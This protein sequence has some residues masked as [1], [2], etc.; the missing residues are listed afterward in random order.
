MSNPQKA[1]EFLQKA[2]RD[3]RVTLLSI[4]AEGGAP[5]GVTFSAGNVD[6]M[7]SWIAEREGKSNL[8]FQ[9]NPLKDDVKDKKAKRAE[10]K[11]VVQLHVDI[12]DLDGLERLSSFE[13]PPTAVVFSGN[14]YHGYWH[15]DKPLT[16]FELVERINKRLAE[17]LGGDIGTQNVDRILRIPFTTN[18]PD[19]KKRAKGRV[20]VGA[21]LVDEQTNFSRIYGIA[22]FEGLLDE[23]E[24]DPANTGTSSEA[25]QVTKSV[26]YDEDGVPIDLTAETKQ[27]ILT[28]GKIGKGGYHSRS[29]A[30]FRVVCDMARARF[31]E[32]VIVKIITNPKFGISASVRDKAKPEVYARRQAKTAK[33]A[34]SRSWD[35]T[36]NGKNIRSTLRN[37]HLAIVALGV[38]CTFDR[39]K[40]R[41]LVNGHAVQEYVG[42]LTD[43]LEAHLRHEILNNF[44]FDPGKDNVRDATQQLALANPFNSI[45]DYFDGL[46]WDRV[47]RLERLLK[48]YFGGEDTAFNRSIGQK[49]LLAAVRRVRQPGTKFD[50]MMVLE[51]EQGTGKSTAIAI[52]AGPE[53]FSDQSI[54]AAD[55]KAQAEAVQGVLLFE[56]S[57]LDGLSRAEMSKVKAF[58]SRSVDRIRHAYARHRMDQPRTCV[59]IG[60]TNE[61]TYLRDTTGNRRFWPVSVGKI[62]LEALKRDRD[63]LWAEAAYLE[64]QGQVIALEA[65]LYADAEALQS[66]RQEIDPWADVLSSV[67]GERDGETMRVFSSTLLGDKLRISSDNQKNFHA[68]RLAAVMHSLGWDGPK[69]IRISGKPGRGY[70]RTVQHQGKLL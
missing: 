36:A 57:E 62:D 52:L 61:D 12:D 56:V 24:A 48:N 22:D 10:I 4:P 18:L 27:L 70:T 66:L 3:D 37:A 51:G 26:E 39:F 60:T 43:Q 67:E 50:F 28:G 1:A 11:H 33:D 53:N 47:P 69:P 6:A 40:G 14:G 34:V 30:L 55:D 20:P 44:G 5:T 42:E 13:V 49:V 23:D 59:F 35:Y 32:S 63:Q 46:E 16:E 58:L 68:K 29:E 2:V 19:K 25:A 65:E 41:Y 31:P 21:H 64:A 45:V 17:L 38:V 7:A 8:Y 9:V 15:L 54:L